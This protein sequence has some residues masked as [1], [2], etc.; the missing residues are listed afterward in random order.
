VSASQQDP[1]A[2]VV[3]RLR[4]LGLP[5]PLLL[6]EDALTPAEWAEKDAQ[7]IPTA[8]GKRGLGFY[9]ADQ[10]PDG[11]VQV[12]EPTATQTTGGVHDEHWVTVDA[13]AAHRQT[14]QA[15]GQ[16]VRRIPGTPRTGGR[17]WLFTPPQIT[18]DRVSTRVTQ[19][20]QVRTTHAR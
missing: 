4:A 11:Y 14:A 19:Q 16:L 6:P 5:G 15:L 2:L 3:A 8:K 20:F 7:G 1:L 18:S 10:A 12:Y 9:L 17:C 13:V